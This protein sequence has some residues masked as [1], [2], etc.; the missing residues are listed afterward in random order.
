[1]ALASQSGGFLTVLKNKNFLRLWLAQ[2]LSMTLLNA[3]NYALLILIDNVTGSTT[4]VGL[5]IICFSLPAVLFG[6]PAGVFVDHMNKRLVLWAS[7]CLRAFATL[8]FILA[9]LIDRTALLP[10]Y[11]LTFLIST[12]G[13]F[14]T[15]AE[16][17]T[18]PILVGETELLPALSLFNITFMLS[19]ALGYVLFAPIL[20]SFLPTFKIFNIPFDSTVQLYMIV[21]VLYFVCAGLILLIP[22]KKFVHVPSTA[23][24]TSAAATQSIK[25]LGNVWHE[26]REGWEFIRGNKRLLFAVIQ[27]SFAGVLMLVIVQLATPIVTQLLKFPAKQM[28]LVFAPAGLGLVFGSV[29]MPRI[30]LHISKIRL[31]LMGIAAIAVATLLLPLITMLARFLQPQGWSGNPLLL[32]AIALVMCLAGFALDFINIPAQTAM[33]ELTPDWIKGRVLSLQLVLYNACS[34]PVILFIGAFADLFGVDRVLYLLSFCEIAFGAWSIYYHRKNLRP[35]P[36]HPATE[37]SNLRE[38]ST[39][40]SSPT[41]LH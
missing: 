32:V 4:L 18:I 5:A 27:L 20:L 21:V 14:F 1:M 38:P 22:R 16:G 15:P 41:P 29:L 30:S 12:I 39:L 31:M 17:S 40:D 33:Q 11:L 13:Q 10:I 7:N 8:L 2:L 34:I 37:V 23:A 28:A 35:V 24:L 25:V 36:I 9:L 3:S 6:A 19:Q 26:M